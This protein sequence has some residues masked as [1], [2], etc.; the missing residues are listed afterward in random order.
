MPG[1]WERLARHEGGTVVALASVPTKGGATL[2]AAT[3]AGLFRS[4][5]AGHTWEAAGEMLLPLLAA[6]APSARFAENRLLFAGTQTGFHRSTDAGHTWR[7]TLSGGRVFAIALVPGD[8]QEERL[9]IGTDMDGILRSEDGGQTWTG[10]NP[11]LLDFTVLALAFSPD[12]AHDH[13]GF[14]ATASGLYR[15][16]NGGRSWRTV[17]WPLD[18]PA[19]QCLALSPAFA[20]DRL[21]L[22]GTESD[23][24]WRSDDGGATWDR[25]PGLPAGRIDALA[26]STPYAATRLVAAATAAGVALSRDGGE[27]WSLTGAALPPVFALA[28]IADGDAETLVAGLYRGGVARL[29]IAEGEGRWL[30][31]N[32]GLE[33]TF[34]STLIAS[35]PSAIDQLLVAAG[36]DAGIR[37]SRDG[38]RRWADAGLIDMVVYGAV[39]V[40]DAGDSQVVI[41]AT[42]AG[43]Y[44]SRNAGASWQ[45]S[46]PG[47][48]APT[49]S[50]VAGSAAGDE[51]TP[52]LAATLDGRLIAS[53]DGG[54]IWRALDT[55]FG[56]A[57]VVSIAH[58]P[59]RTLYAGTIQPMTAGGGG[60]V[61]LWRSTDAGGTWVR[62]L[63]ERGGTGTLPLALPPGGDDGPFVGL[64]NRVLQPRRNAWQT[65]GGMRS[66]LWSGASL[67]TDGGNPAA[68]TALAVSPNYPADGMVFAATS[69][70]VY[71][72]RD[73]GRAFDRWNDGLG[74]APVLAL[75]ATVADGTP[76]LFALGIDGTIWRR[77]CDA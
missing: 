34:L 61:T 2:F 59:N 13:T 23:G 77:R 36:P 21:V 74:P 72:S 69:A 9:F 67:M 5:D 49:G 71:R 30:P 32:A 35:P 54:G 52:V 38:G 41:A 45:G 26:F 58:A 18:D 57:A 15:T 42:E 43:I 40:L 11:G 68:I 6:V 28:F 66:P 4:S 12:A 44:R 56:G 48:E 51:Y 14:A 64:G 31:A 27:T 55:P 24:L 8:G 20:D 17:E 16:R 46:L 63:E 39:C 73:R 70:G 10:A 22:A 1:G 3:A 47:G 19:V 33:A 65:R 75:A 62:W 53:D 50:V 25:V 60:E 76:I 29:A 37:F 7:Q